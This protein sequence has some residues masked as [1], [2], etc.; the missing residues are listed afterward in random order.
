MTV[1]QRLELLER[2]LIRANR[3]SSW[4]LGGALTAFSLSIALAWALWP[5]C[6]SAEQAGLLPKIVRA[7]LFVVED[8]KG[9][10]RMSI[11][12]GKEGVPALFLQ[13]ENGITR[14]SLG[15]GKTG[16]S[17]GLYD[18]TGKLRVSV[19]VDKIGGAQLSLADENAI[20]RAGMQITTL[21]PVL[22]LSDEKLKASVGISVLKNK[23]GIICLDAGGKTVW[24]AP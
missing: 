18:E 20:P 6:A 10:E 4:V 7:N 8:L 14:A 11:G 22:M 21:G 13:D 16:P 5:D 15:C 1:E 17:L 24:G 2:Q 19:Q 12:V 3:R 23:P 9:K